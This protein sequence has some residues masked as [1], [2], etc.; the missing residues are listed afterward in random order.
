MF[1]ILGAVGVPFKSQESAANGCNWSVLLAK[2][3]TLIARPKQALAKR[4]G[5]QHCHP[6]P[7]ASTQA[8]LFRPL[9]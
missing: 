7:A 1:I 3:D 5:R 6:K 2:S 9:F 4:C 8:P